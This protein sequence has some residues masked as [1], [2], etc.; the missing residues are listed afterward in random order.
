MKALSS[1]I[2][3]FGSKFRIRRIIADLKQWL[4]EAELLNVQYLAFVLEIEH[5]KILEWYDVEF[6]RVN[7][8][9]DETLSHLNERESEETSQATSVS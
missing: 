7:D 2:G 1:E 4:L 6:G 9:L 3:Q 5:G 8:S